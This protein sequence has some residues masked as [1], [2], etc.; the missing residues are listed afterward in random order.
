VKGWQGRNALAT[1]L[2]RVLAWL[3]G[4]RSRRAF[5]EGEIAAVASKLDVSMRTVYRDLDAIRAAGRPVPY[6]RHIG[7]GPS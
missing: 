7:K 3:D 6:A 5:S 1:R 2:I 4:R